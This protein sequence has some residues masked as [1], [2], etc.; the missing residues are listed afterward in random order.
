ML[1]A[2]W[3]ILSTSW[4][5]PAG[6]KPRPAEK[7]GKPENTYRQKYTSPRGTS[8]SNP[9]TE[10]NTNSIRKATDKYANAM[11][12][13]KATTE[14]STPYQMLN[15]QLHLL[16]PTHEMW[17]L[18]T[19]LI[20]AIKPSKEMRYGVTRSTS[21][22][23]GNYPLVL[24]HNIL[25]LQQISLYAKTVIATNSNDVAENYCPFGYHKTALSFE[26]HE[27]KQ[28]VR[29]QSG[30][31][32]TDLATIRKEVN[33]LSEDLDVKLDVIHNVLLEFRVETQGQLA[34]LST[35]LAELI[36][37]VT[38]GRDDKKVEVG[39]SHG[40]GQPPPGD[41]GNSGS[42]S[43]P[44]RKRGSSGSRQK[45]WRYWLNE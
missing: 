3:D 7:P 41:G 26:V 4:A 30:I 44:S 8:G 6:S 28:G 15:K 38:K 40:R 24:D 31:F 12:G 35:N 37:F 32:S 45:S 27:F 16:L 9:S 1:Y 5:P 21:E 29:A 19:P 39:S 10:S 11:Q 17:E 42:R 25:I 34:S 23:Y 13:I 14:S 2:N 22:V 18:P 33:D 43:E 36:A 20:A